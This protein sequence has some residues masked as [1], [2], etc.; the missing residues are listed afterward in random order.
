MTGI[1]ICKFSYW[2]LLFDHFLF[3][4]HSRKFPHYFHLVQ[5][6]EQYTLYPFMQHNIIH[7]YICMYSRYTRA[8]IYT[9]GISNCITIF[10]QRW[11]GMVHFH[12]SKSILSNQNWY[13]KLLFYGYYQSSRQYRTNIIHKRSLIFAVTLIYNI[14]IIF[15]FQDVGSIMYYIKKKIRLAYIYIYI[16]IHYMI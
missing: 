1:S 13:R 5:T 6:N 14:F 8:L 9:V 4:L 7:M 12:W 11:Y 10:R 15:I 16:Y 2:V 3:A